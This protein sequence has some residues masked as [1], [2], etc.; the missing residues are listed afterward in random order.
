MKNKL[1]S[2][3]SSFV[4]VFTAIC[5]SHAEA[6]ETTIYHSQDDK[7]NEQALGYSK[8]N[9]SLS[10]YLAYRD[11]P[12]FIAQ[13]CHGKTS[14]DYGAGTG[15]STQFLQ[16]Q[17]LEVTGVDI[18]KEMLAQAILN[19]PD[20]SFYLIQNGS[21]PSMPETYDLI[22]SSLVLFELGSEKEILTYLE[23]AKRVL[24]KD[25]VFIAVTGSQEMYSKDWL[26]FDTDFPENKNL[27]SGDLARIY[28]CDADIEFTDYYWT[29]A[30][31]RR[32][33]NQAGFQ[34]L[35]VHYPKGKAS[36][37]Y[38]WKDEKT[39]SPFVVLVAEKKP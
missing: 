9:Q 32:L 30:D 3:I 11:I 8:T 23:E 27:K 34:L 14:L 17:A 1:I 16:E 20:A 19:C 29:E 13:Y 24:K 33:F 28:L 26:I 25:G 21:I 35:E 37:P 2:V 36:E 15:F 10:R 38:S 4:F 6:D 31:Y 5:L 7:S 39:S 12:P 22:F 18:S